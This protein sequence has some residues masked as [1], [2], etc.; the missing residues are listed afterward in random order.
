MPK[1]TRHHLHHGHATKVLG[2]VKQWMW[3]TYSV[4]FFVKHEG[5]NGPTGVGT[6]PGLTMDSNSGAADAK[7]ING[8][9]DSMRRGGHCVIVM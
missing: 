6:G 4:L 3:R 2:H 8:A 1:G 9:G 7:M 5:G